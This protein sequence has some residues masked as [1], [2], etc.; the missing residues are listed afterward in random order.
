[1]FTHKTGKKYEKRQEKINRDPHKRKKGLK[2]TR[3]VRKHSR[4]GRKNG[5]LSG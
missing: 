1:V 2:K 3:L 4:Q 5:V